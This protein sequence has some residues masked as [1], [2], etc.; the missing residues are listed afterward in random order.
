MP[1]P[2]LMQAVLAL[3]NAESEAERKRVLESQRDVLLTDDAEQLLNDWLAQSAGKHART[4][5]ES[6]A[7]LARCRQEGIE[8]AF[9]E[10]V[11][12]LSSSSTP[13]DLDALLDEI[14]SLSQPPQM[15]R[16]VE[17][18]REALKLVKREDDPEQWAS[19]HL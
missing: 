19:V 16:R 5:Q 9:A 10:P 6:L 14:D 2:T 3:I 8:G 18:C 13:N 11:R 12:P 17:L 15:P 7:L 4:L 1:N